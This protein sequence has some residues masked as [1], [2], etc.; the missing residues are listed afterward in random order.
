M[1][2]HTEALP[3][4]DIGE[5]RERYPEMFSDRAVDEIYCDSGWKNLLIALCDTLQ[6]YLNRHP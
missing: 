6:D 1:T 3:E 5:F 2:Q 4:I